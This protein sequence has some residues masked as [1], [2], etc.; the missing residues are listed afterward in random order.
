MKS[1]GPELQKG[2]GQIATPLLVATEGGTVAGDAR[3]D[4]E[5][6]SGKKVVSKENYLRSPQDKKLLKK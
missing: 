4:L 2:W 6:R 1:R 3:Q 5:K